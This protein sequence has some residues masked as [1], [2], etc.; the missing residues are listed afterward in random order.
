MLDVE[1]MVSTMG[2]DLQALTSAVPAISHPTSQ[3]NTEKGEH[4]RV[5]TPTVRKTTDKN[6]YSQQPGESHMAYFRN[7]LL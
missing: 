4:R 3:N 7:I 6:H 5:E 1:G 2:L